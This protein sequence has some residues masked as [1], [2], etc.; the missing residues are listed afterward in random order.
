MPTRNETVHTSAYVLSYISR[1]HRLIT[2]HPIPPEKMEKC[3]LR[4][5]NAPFLGSSMIQDYN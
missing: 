2:D 5:M 4:C 1:I 3:P